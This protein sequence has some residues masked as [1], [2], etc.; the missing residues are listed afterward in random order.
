VCGVLDTQKEARQTEILDG[1]GNSNLMG[2]FSLRLWTALVDTHA[3]MGMTVLGAF[4]CGI[5]SQTAKK[6]DSGNKYIYSERI[7]DKLRNSACINERILF[8]RQAWRI[9]DAVMGFGIYRRVYTAPKPR[10]TASS[11]SSSSPQ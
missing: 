11:S 8:T 2:S 9:C 6:M 3:Q 10:R 7:N 1:K 5:T 4:R